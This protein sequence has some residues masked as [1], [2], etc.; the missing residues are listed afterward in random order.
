[1]KKNIFLFLA[2]TIFITTAKSQIYNCGKSK[3]QIDSTFVLFINEKLTN[4]NIILCQDQ[5]NACTE[6]EFLK[7]HI[8]CISKKQLRKI[9]YYRFS[10]LKKDNLFYTMNEL[11]IKNEKIAKKIVENLNTTDDMV[12]TDKGRTKFDFFRVRNRI[13]FYFASSGSYENNHSV[14]LELKDK[15]YYAK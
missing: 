1:M 2:I 7:K 12:L 15:L 11:F 8:P 6:L 14:F 3:Q 10:P 9:F 5:T 13:Y 4:N